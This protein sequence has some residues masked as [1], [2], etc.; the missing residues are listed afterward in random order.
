MV[1]DITALLNMLYVFQQQHLNALNDLMTGHLPRILFWLAKRR[2]G[3]YSRKC[4]AFSTLSNH[5]GLLQFLEACSQNPTYGSVCDACCDGM[6]YRGLINSP[7][8]NT[9]FV[10]SAKN[11]LPMKF[12][13]AMKQ[14]IEGLGCKNLRVCNVP[15]GVSRGRVSFGCIPNFTV[16]QKLWL[17]F[18]FICCWYGSWLTRFGINVNRY[19]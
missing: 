7:I 10:G 14:F 11:Q 8:F 17:R 9:P 12:G 15:D 16:V 2:N 5:G 18:Y 19:A 6:L 1:N 4:V 13:F 3:V